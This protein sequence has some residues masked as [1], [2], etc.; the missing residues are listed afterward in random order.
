M[1]KYENPM[2]FYFSPLYFQTRLYGLTALIYD[3]P[4]GYDF[5]FRDWNKAVS[6]ALEFLRMKNDIHYLTQCR[7]TSL[8]YDALTGF[9]NMSEFR[10]RAGEAINEASRMLA[11]KMSFS[12][13]GE[14]IYG[15]NYKSDI[16]AAAARAVRQA[17]TER[18]IYCRTDNDILIVLC[19]EKNNVVF[20]KAKVIL[21]H[22]ICGKYG[23]NQVIIS[24]AENP[25]C[26]ADKIDDLCLSVENAANTAVKRLHQ[27]ETL[28]QYKPLLGCS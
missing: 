13:D 26:S 4:G 18:E 3:R 12:S 11:V 7:R 23:E 27:R 25:D 28:P 19:N 24:F 17:C 20:E 5:S 21:H 15:D 6:V 1:E 10:R 8:L 22:D 16:V 14:Y 9:Y 2:I